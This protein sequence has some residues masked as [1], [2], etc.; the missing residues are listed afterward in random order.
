MVSHE[1]N[2]C[3]DRKEKIMHARFLPLLMRSSKTRML[4][5]TIKPEK[6]LRLIDNSLQFI[7]LDDAKDQVY[8]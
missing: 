4:D 7:L 1:L 2:N 5:E 3:L 6:D 8:S